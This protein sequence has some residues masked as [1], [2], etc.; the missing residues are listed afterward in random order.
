MPPTRCPALEAL[1]DRLA[2]EAVAALREQGA[3]LARLAVA[4]RLH[5][6]YAGTEAALPVALGRV[7][8]VT[9]A[10]T[11]AHRARFGFATP[12]RALIVE[13]VAVEATA[14]GEPVVEATHPRPRRRRA[15]RRSTPSDVERRRA[16]TRRR[17]SSA[18]RCCAGDVIAGPALIRE[19]NATTVV[20]P[21]WSAEVT[22]LDHM[23]LRRTEPR[24]TSVAAGTRAGRP[25]AAGT[26]QQ[27][28]HERRRADRR[29]AAE[30]LAEREHQGAAGL[31]L[32]HLR[33][34]GRAW[35]RTRRTCRCI[36]AP[37]ARACARCIAHRG[38]TLRPGDV[39]ALN[40]P[41]NGGTHLPDVTVITPVF[42]AA[43]SEILFFVGNRGH[44]ADIGGITPGSTPP[45]SRTLEEEG[46]VIDDFLLVEQGHFREAELRALLGR[47]ALSG[48][49]PRRE[50]RRHQ[51]AGGGQREGRAGTAPRG[52]A[53]R[54]GRGA[55]LHAPRH[56]QRRG[57]RA[58]GDRPHRRRR[59]STTRMDNGAP[60]RVRVS[61]DRAGAHRAGR[62]HRHRA[63][64]RAAT[65]TPRRR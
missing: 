23:L 45:M 47:G 50:R 39:V 25:G 1:A 17:C 14:A 46:V 21:G 27:P 42:D 3:D 6:R 26:V 63:A 58:A 64:E 29:G 41:F 43:G 40:N 35:W 61:V 62:F 48:A 59:A 33:R 22:A 55:R 34:R 24:A 11:A 54:L 7:E 36:S 12:G 19:A 37:W 30:H 8:A 38:A 32:R 10:F 18:P 20:E 16:R 4:R 57:E 5:V 31:L 2:A 65:S 13:A 49:Q 28:V 53:V 60:L 15:R 52:R 9:A 51:G 56:G 44:H